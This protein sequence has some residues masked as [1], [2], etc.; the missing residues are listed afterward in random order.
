MKS[1]YQIIVIGAGTAGMMVASQLL[2]KNKTLDIAIIDPSEQHYYQPAWTL[3]GAGT[4][5]Y[6]RTAKPTKSLIPIFGLGD[7]AALP[8]AKTG[9]AIRKQ[10]PVVVDNIL[11]MIAGKNA[12]NT[13]YAGYSS[14]PLVT[15][16]G[17]MVLAE[18]NYKNE[19]TPDPNLKKMLIYDSFKEHWRLW[20]LKK[21][22]LPYLYWNKMMKGKDV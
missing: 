18:F 13:S 5:S 9:A 19:F 10:A 8:T 20:I 7:V 16:Y 22:M 17:K 2:R 3:V 15:G 12:D 11:N 1:H 21:Y 6:A 4:Y 14:C